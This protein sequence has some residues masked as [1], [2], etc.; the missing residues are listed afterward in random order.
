M[1][2]FD[3]RPGLMKRRVND[4][5]LKRWKEYDDLFTDSLWMIDARDRSG[6]HTNTYHGN[7]VPQIPNQL[8]RRFTKKGGVVLDCFLGNGTTLIESKKL[9]RNGIGVELL[10]SVARGA[11][12]N[13][14]E[15]NGAG[16]TEIVVGD[17][18]GAKARKGVEG[19]LK[20]MKKKAVQLIILHP[21]Y[22]DI[23]KFSG[24]KEDLSNATSVEKFTN[25][26]GDVVENFSGLLEQ[27]GSLAIVIGDKYEAGEWH[28]LAFYLLQE[29]LR[30]DTSLKLKSVIIKNMA[31]NRAKLNQEK[32]WR[33]R[34][35]S[36]GFY[37][38]KHEYILLF[39][40]SL[41]AGRQ[42]DKKV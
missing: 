10:P 2:G 17:S 21:P 41:P 18:A 3:S 40:K 27:G 6:A 33:Y 15:G 36:G 4:L 24:K 16:K 39:R 11:Q 26:F 37:I 42:A 14:E 8:M 32:L 29:T 23:I 13:I 5:E 1:R 28:P 22:H 31:G 38:F 25:R 19:A 12:K 30:R 20:G 9:G 35:L 7:F 34:A